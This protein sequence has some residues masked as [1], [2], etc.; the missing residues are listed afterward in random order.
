MTL[1]PDTL[2]T[3]VARSLNLLATLECATTHYFAEAPV[4]APLVPDLTPPRR[5][6]PSISA[7][8]DTADGQGA[9]RAEPAPLRSGHP[10]TEPVAQHT[11]RPSQTGR[12]QARQ[13]SPP[14]PELQVRIDRVEI[15]RTPPSDPPRQGSGRAPIFRRS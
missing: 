9:T 8:T 6:E 1:P 4:V 7:V 5:S 3:L 2:R 14:E 11:A 13:I 15:T 12:R 10:L